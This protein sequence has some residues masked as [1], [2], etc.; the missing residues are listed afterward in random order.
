GIG[1]G[2]DREPEAAE[3][4]V[5]I[6]VAVPAAVILLQVEGDRRPA[7]EA[8]RLLG[9]EDRL[10]RL[11]AAAGADVDAPG[12]VVLAVDRERDGAR[13]PLLLALVVEDRLE[14]RF[15]RL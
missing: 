8:H 4:A 2:S 13:E 12:R 9:H 15:G 7:G 11:V 5:L 10:A 1:G 14:R 3:V 6:V